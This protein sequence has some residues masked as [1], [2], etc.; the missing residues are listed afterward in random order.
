MRIAPNSL[1][2]STHFN[3]D[4]SSR[5][6]KNLKAQWLPNCTNTHCWLPPFD[7][8]FHP[9]AFTS[10]ILADKLIQES[11]D[12][13]KRGLMFNCTSLQLNPLSICKLRNAPRYVVCTAVTGGSPVHVLRPSIYQDVWR[14]IPYT[15]FQA[16]NT[17]GFL[18]T[19]NWIYL[20]LLTGAWDMI[21]QDNPWFNNPALTLT[22]TILGLVTY[23]R[24]QSKHAGEI[25]INSNCGKL[26]SPTISNIFSSTNFSASL[27]GFALFQ[28][29]L[30]A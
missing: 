27:H 8:G 5:I 14:S 20:N 29:K 3:E 12:G 15:L 7:H 18:L 17:Q 13:W 25:V 6:W 24:G 4:L 22:M 2:N 19:I 26:E 28:H 30:A 9:C 11:A 10:S 23:Y 21:S 1:L 16:Q